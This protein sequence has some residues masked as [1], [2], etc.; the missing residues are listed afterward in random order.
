MSG[1]GSSPRPYSVDKE[2][3]N[4]NWDTIFNDP[5]EKDDA[6]AEDEAFKEIADRQERNTPRSSNGRAASLHGADGSS[7]LSRGT[8]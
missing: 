3:F 4:N 1:K 5:K 8:K 6:L 7:I 2:T